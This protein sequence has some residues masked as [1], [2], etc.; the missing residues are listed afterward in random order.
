MTPAPRTVPGR[1]NSD[2]TA[3]LKRRTVVALLAVLAICFGLVPLP[4]V[5][6]AGRSPCVC[7]AGTE[8]HGASLE[9][10]LDFYQFTDNEG[11]VH[12]VDSPEKIPRRYRDKV[13]AR[14]ETFAAR[15]T[16]KVKIIDR[17][18]HV[19]VTLQRG[20]R[21]V[22][23]ALLLDTGASVTVITEELAGRLGIQPQDGRPGKTRLA[24]GS[25]IDLR[26]VRVDAVM[27]G[28]RKK[29]PLEIGIIQ[30]VGN[31]ELHDGLL[32]LDFLGDFQYQIDMDNELIRWQ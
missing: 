28:S 17:Q 15:Q 27:V 32:G 3:S 12:F 7:A 8:V 23:A 24:D 30:H 31:R 20:D 5:P 13:I 2:P 6:L 22:P 9:E 4:R 25:E 18:I 10:N 1:N 16:T 21:G 29:A 14:K 19:P 26:L 11:T